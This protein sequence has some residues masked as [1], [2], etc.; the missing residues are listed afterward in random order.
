VRQ[1]T[2]T[3]RHALTLVGTIVGTVYG[4]ASASQGQTLYLPLD[5]EVKAAL[6][7]TVYA[8]ETVLARLAEHG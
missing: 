1:G 6:G 2:L 5:A 3:R 4:S 7:D 8:A